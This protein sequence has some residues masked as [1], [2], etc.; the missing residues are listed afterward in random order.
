MSTHNYSPGQDVEALQNGQWVPAHIMNP[1][2]NGTYDIVIGRRPQFDWPEANLRGEARPFTIP[3]QP[4]ISTNDLN[5]YSQEWYQENGEAAEN[6]SPA[7]RIEDFINYVRDRL[8]MDNLDVQTE[9]MIRQYAE[10]NI[11]TLFDDENMPPQTGGRKRQRY[12]K[13]RQAKR[14]TNKRRNSRKT[15]KK[16]SD[17]KKRRKTRRR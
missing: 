16:H 3:N 17:G 9:Q 4:A 7:N 5:E 12:S 10:Q 8:N 1:N 14:K 2:T 11:S 13:K 6:F 15:M